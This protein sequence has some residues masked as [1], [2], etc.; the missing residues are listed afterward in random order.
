MATQTESRSFGFVFRVT[1]MLRSNSLPQMILI[2]VFWQLRR[3][4]LKQIDKHGPV[5]Q[6]EIC[7]KRNEK[8]TDSCFLS[9]WTDEFPGLSYV[10]I[11][12]SL[13]IIVAFSKV[14]LRVIKASNMYRYQPNS[15]SNT[16][17]RKLSVVIQNGAQFQQ[18][19]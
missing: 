10:L 6:R 5:K 9:T 19:V 7:K 18:P 13:L 17:V 2:Q 16:Q 4:I 8:K 12:A 14:R 11:I 15:C 3:V 1:K